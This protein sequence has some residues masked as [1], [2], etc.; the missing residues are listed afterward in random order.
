MFI[1]K[2]KF[3]TAER[4]AKHSPVWYALENVLTFFYL[5]PV[6][7]KIRKVNCEGLKPPYLILGNHASMVDFPM[8]IKATRPH[9]LHW[10]SS[11][12]EFVG[13]EYMFRRMGMIYKRKFTND[14]TVVRHILHVLKKQSSIVGI[15]PEARFGLAGV[16]ERL[17]NALGKLVKTAKVPVVTLILSGNFL[18]SP[19]WNKHPYRKVKVSGVMEQIVTREEAETL[20]AEE[21]QRRIEEKFDYDEYGRQAAEKIEIKCKERAT[22]LHKILYQCPACKKEFSTYAKG[23]KIWCQSCGAVWNMDYFGNLVREDGAE[24]G[25]TI[26]VPE[27][28]NW[29]RA[30]VREEVRSGNYRFEDEARLELLA[31]SHYGFKAL[32]TVKLTHDYNG[33]S[34]TGEIDGKPFSFNRDPATM[35]SCHVEYDFKGRGDAIDLCTLNDT[36]FVFP[37]SAVNPLTKLHFATEELH[38]YVAEIRKEGK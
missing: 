34:M 25:K 22:N 3:N 26:S 23:A 5:A 12:E 27:W 6:G 21:I 33:F 11:I 8:M 9:P 28:Y 10:V 19:Q 30:N 14:I 1:H 17:D 29:E 13:R 38:D 18:R 2:E 37:L 24:A 36:Y 16:N 32:G 20:S 7:G 35:I 31:N 15:Y 4:P